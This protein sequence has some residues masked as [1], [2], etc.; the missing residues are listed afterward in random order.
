MLIRPIDYFLL[1][2]F[3]LVAAECPSRTSVFNKPFDGAQLTVCPSMAGSLRM[4]HASLFMDGCDA[5]IARSRLPQ[6]RVVITGPAAVP[7]WP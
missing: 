7:G 6:L 2:W 3:A 4:H 1:A 5:R